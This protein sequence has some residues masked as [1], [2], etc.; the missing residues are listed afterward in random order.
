M[1]G[2]FVSTVDECK[3]CWIPCTAGCG[4]EALADFESPR[5]AFG[6]TVCIK[7]IWTSLCWRASTQAV[8]R[9]KQEGT[10]TRRLVS[11]FIVSFAM[12]GSFLNILLTLAYDCDMFFADELFYLLNTLLRFV[13]FL[14]FICNNALIIC[15]NSVSGRE[16]LKRGICYFSNLY[17]KDQTSAI[18]YH[19]HISYQA[20]AQIK[21]FVKSCIICKCVYP[22]QD[23]SAVYMYPCPK[24]TDP[25]TREGLLVCSDCGLGLDVAAEWYCFPIYIAG[26]WSRKAIPTGPDSVLAGLH[27][28]LCTKL[29]MATKP[30]MIRKGLFYGDRNATY[31]E[32]NSNNLTSS[33]KKK[34]GI[35]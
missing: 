9:L 23:L 3:P 25:P 1:K 19:A 11:K 24:I 13:V 15:Y 4:R 7:C 34:T 20:L 27:G 35:V 17:K 8:V 32:N 18:G 33:R 28:M 22:I 31:V 16:A 10:Y 12:I 26:K 29:E 30:N 2:N 5:L 21:K 6:N 14:S